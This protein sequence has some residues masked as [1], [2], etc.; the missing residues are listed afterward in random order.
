MELVGDVGQPDW[1][2]FVLVPNFE[3]GSGRVFDGGEVEDC[4]DEGGD[5]GDDVM[6]R[7]VGIET[8]NIGGLAGGE[9]GFGG[10]LEILGAGTVEMVDDVECA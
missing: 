2:K 6:V 9:G 10:G 8:A 1:F 7:N 4:M 3:A 5:A